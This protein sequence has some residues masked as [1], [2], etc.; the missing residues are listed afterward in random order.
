MQTEAS[1]LDIDKKTT[2]S[3]R[4]YLVPDLPF[5]ISVV[6]SSILGPEASTQAWIIFYGLMTGWLRLR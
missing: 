6:S 2:V 3:Q 5:I 1:H 4:Q